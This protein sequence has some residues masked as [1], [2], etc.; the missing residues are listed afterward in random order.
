MLKPLSLKLKSLTTLGDGI[1]RA[2]YDIA[3]QDMDAKTTIHEK[4]EL[5]VTPTETIARLDI[6][7]CE[8]LTP[9]QALDKLAFWLDGFSLALNAREKNPPKVPIY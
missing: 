2:E 1:A 4:L 7:N 6:T 5:R 9:G 8:A 3:L